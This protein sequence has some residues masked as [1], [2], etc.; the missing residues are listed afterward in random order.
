MRVGIGYDVHSLGPG[1]GVILGGVEVP[2][3]KKLEGWSDADVV[4][5]AI[6]DALLGAAGLGDIGSWFPAGDPEYREISSLSLLSRVRDVFK[7][8]GIKIVNVDVTV[9][10]QEPELSPFIDGMRLKLG[11]VL[12]I[13]TERVSVKATTTDGLGF[14]GRGDGIAAQ[15]VVLIQE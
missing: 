11:N 4:V 13:A 9:I 2:C 10:A 6:V 3:G 8:R 5:H 15:A 7:G 1:K 12:E 14:I